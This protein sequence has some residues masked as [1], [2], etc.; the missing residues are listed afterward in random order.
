MTN[1]VTNGSQKTWPHEHEWGHNPT[2]KESVEFCTPCSRKED[3][4]SVQKQCTESRHVKPKTTSV[5]CNKSEFRKVTWNKTVESNGSKVS[6]KVS[7]HFLRTEIASIHKRFG[8]RG[9]AWRALPSVRQQKR[10]G[11]HH[12]GASAER[13]IRS[14]QSQSGPGCGDAMFATSCSSNFTPFR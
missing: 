10:R 3:S 9:R 13:Q 6:G 7:L 2:Q 1:E 14:L 11:A 8:P 12:G 4:W 5:R